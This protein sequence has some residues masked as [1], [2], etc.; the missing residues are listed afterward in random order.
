MLAKNHQYTKQ[1][2]S[3]AITMLVMALFMGACT[4]NIEAESTEDPQL[5]ITHVAETVSAQLEQTASAQPTPTSTATGTPTLTATISPTATV[6]DMKRG[7]MP[8]GNTASTTYQQPAAVT[9]ACDQAGFLADVTIPDGTVIEPG[10]TF[11][12]T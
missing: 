12:K 10:V 4:R 2:I 5:L 3:I 7:G 8:S 6:Q 11:T 9:I 1:Q